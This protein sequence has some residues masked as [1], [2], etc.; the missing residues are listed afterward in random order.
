MIHF[1][2]LVI[3]F[4]ETKVINLALSKVCKLSSLLHTS[5]SFKEK[6]EGQFGCYGIRQQN[7]TRWNSLLRQVKAV[8]K[9]D[10]NRLNDL[11]QELGQD[12]LVITT[13]QQSHLKELEELLTPF[14][15]ATDISQGEKVT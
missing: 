9:L 12:N 5:C 3:I 11:C 2:I 15:E 13:R 6:F 10:L 7:S 1:F 4:Q 14:M 8:L